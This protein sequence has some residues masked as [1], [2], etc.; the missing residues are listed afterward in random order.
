MGK[1][2]VIKNVDFGTNRL[3]TVKINDTKPCT[4]IRLNAGS[5]EFTKIGQTFTLVPTITPADTTDSISWSTSNENVA[6]VASGVVTQVGVG[7]CVITATCGSHSATCEISATNEL[8]YEVFLTYTTTPFTGRDY[9]VHTNLGSGEHYACVVQLTPATEKKLYSDYSS[10]VYPIPLGKNASTINVSCPSNIRCTVQQ[11]N[12]DEAC[13]YSVDH[14]S[15]AVYA[16]RISGSDT[17]YDPNVSLGDRIITVDEGVNAAVF[18]F[19]KP[20]SGNAMT[21]ED[22]ENISIIVS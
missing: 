3:T 18:S 13:D 6:T 11:M 16:K 4:S 12:C 5:L 15:Y 20:G 9:V 19:Q 2:L 8:S 22:F 17:A 1:A 14:S 21:A 10:P 7:S